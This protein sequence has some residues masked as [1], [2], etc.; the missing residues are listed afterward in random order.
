MASAPYVSG[1]APVAQEPC[2]CP[3]LCCCEGVGLLLLGIA[4]VLL[5]PLA[6]AIKRG[7]FTVSFW[8]CLLLTLLGWLP[9][10]VYALYIVCVDPRRSSEGGVVRAAA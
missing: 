8:L 5:P 1:P 2:F 7:V 4:A 9:G 10:Q 3:C 6:V